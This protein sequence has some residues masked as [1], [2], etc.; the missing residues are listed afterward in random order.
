ML[1]CSFYV[2][3]HSAVPADV[4]VNHN[5]DFQTTAPLRNPDIHD[6]LLEII[7]PGKPVI[8]TRNNV[9][10]FQSNSQGVLV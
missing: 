2:H 6:L 3:Y 1:R 5:E 9:Q 8:S 7:S 10:V 4:Q